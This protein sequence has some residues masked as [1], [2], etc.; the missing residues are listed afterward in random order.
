MKLIDYIRLS[1]VASSKCVNYTH[2]NTHCP[3]CVELK[4]YDD[5]I[6]LLPAKVCSTQG[7]YRYCTCQLCGTSFTAYAETT[8]GIGIENDSAV[9]FGPDER[10][11]KSK[12]KVRRK[13]KKS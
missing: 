12:K 8:A 5:S 10:K 9:V 13:R 2:L 1:V 7:D 11:K 6:E 4:K 3:V